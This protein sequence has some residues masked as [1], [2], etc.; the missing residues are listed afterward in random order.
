MNVTLHIERL[1]LDGL[2]VSPGERGQVRAAVEAELARLIAERGP[3][4]GW[5]S[6]GAIPS[7]TA[8]TVEW[9]AG[10]GPA[11]LGTRVGQAIYG[12]PAR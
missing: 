3:A 12:G 10:D 8:G 2:A 1:I 9:Q 5:V 11:A 6:G 7:V 4:E